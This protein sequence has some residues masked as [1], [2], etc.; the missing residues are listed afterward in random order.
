MKISSSPT[1]VGP[2]CFSARLGQ[3]VSKECLL[4]LEAS[5]KKCMWRKFR[6][7]ELSDLLEMRSDNKGS[8]SRSSATEL[9]IR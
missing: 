7:E 6:G 3:W 4:E 2:T 8:H 1:C 9:G 5:T